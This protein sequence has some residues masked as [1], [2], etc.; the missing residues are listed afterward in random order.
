M[1]QMFDSRE[2]AARGSFDREQSVLLCRIY[3]RQSYRPVNC[4]P[5][6]VITWVDQETIN[7]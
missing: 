5:I 3:K 1:L 4:V 2:K 6:F 7:I